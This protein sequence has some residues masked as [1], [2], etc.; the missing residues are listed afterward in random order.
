MKRLRLAI[1]A[2]LLFLAAAP[3][4]A[5][6]G[7]NG[8]DWNPWPVWTPMYWAEEMFDDNDYYGGPWGGYGPYYGG[9]GGYPYNSGYYGGYPNYG[10]Y[11]YP[12]YGNAYGY[13]GYPY[14]GGYQYPGYAQSTR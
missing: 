9:Y 7:G 14:Y 8:W 2:G 5:W 3:A 11:G 1:L 10:N 12:Y 4:Q 13:G 6:W